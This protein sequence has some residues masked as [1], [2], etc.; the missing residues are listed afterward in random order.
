LDILT[1]LTDR[2]GIDGYCGMNSQAMVMQDRLIGSGRI[3]RQESLLPVFRMRAAHLEE[4]A[5]RGQQ[6]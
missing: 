5:G 1:V 4:R 6:E 3:A 2:I